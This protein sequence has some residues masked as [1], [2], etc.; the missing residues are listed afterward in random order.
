[1]NLRARVGRGIRAALEPSPRSSESGPLPCI[2]YRDDDF[3]SDAAKNEVANAALA[4]HDDETVGFIVLAVRHDTNTLDIHAHV[5]GVF[6]TLFLDALAAMYA[7]MRG[8][9]GQ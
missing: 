5:P 3:L 4:L 1:M 7:A 9:L 2:V 8:N 6:H